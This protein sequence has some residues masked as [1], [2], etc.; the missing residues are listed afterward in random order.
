MAIHQKK[1]VINKFQAKQ[2]PTIA[3]FVNGDSSEENEVTLTHFDHSQDYDLKCQ[4]GL[5]EA[6]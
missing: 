4:S 2:K 3:E 1:S 6:Q 5:K